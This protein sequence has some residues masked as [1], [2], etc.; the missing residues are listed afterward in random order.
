MSVTVRKRG[1]R[2]RVVAADSGRLARSKHGRPADGGGH[3]SRAKAR[4]QAQAI[5]AALAEK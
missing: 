1:Q 4:R 5:N 3:A 2:Y